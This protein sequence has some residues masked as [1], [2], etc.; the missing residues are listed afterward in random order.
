[1][2]ILRT[3][4]DGLPHPKAKQQVIN[5]DLSPEFVSSEWCDELHI[6]GS[7]LGVVFR[8]T[9]PEDNRFSVIVWDWTTGEVVLVRAL[10]VMRWSRLTPPI[11][12]PQAPRERASQSNSVLGRTQNPRLGR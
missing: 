6:N 1:M 3:M 7:R 10:I 8:P 2:I 4:T 5:Y 12:S 11:P 9:D